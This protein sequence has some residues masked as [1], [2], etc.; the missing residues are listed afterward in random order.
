MF[1]QERGNKIMNIKLLPPE[2]RSYPAE[3]KFLKA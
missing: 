2:E 1:P 3:L